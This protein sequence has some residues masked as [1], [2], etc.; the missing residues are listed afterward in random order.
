[1]TAR[2]LKR[3]YPVIPVRFYHAGLSKEE[4]TAIE[5]W[6]FDSDDGVLAS[7]CAYGMG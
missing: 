4:K 1:M 6:L 2:L 7:T 5:K 3:A